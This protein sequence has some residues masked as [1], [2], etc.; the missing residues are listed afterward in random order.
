MQ[1]ISSAYQ[2]GA[3]IPARFTCEGDNISP[4]FS[5]QDAPK[6]TRS[7]V[8]ML[9]DPDA[10]R[11]NGFMHWVV[12]NIPA[13]TGHVEEGVPGEANVPGLGLQAK[14]DSGRTGYMGPCPPAGRHRYF[15]RL[16]ALKKMLPLGEGVPYQEVVSAMEGAI[17]EQAEL[18]GTYAKGAQRAA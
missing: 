6:E 14:N 12:Y 1:L 17:I 15:A 13:E 7:F 11:R 10:P 8:L 2:H 3:E 16:Y 5:W 9:H 18:L 4:E